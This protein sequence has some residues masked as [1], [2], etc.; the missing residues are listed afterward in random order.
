MSPGKTPSPVLLF[1]VVSEGLTYGTLVEESLNTTDDYVTILKAANVLWLEVEVFNRWLGIYLKSHAPEVNTA[2]LILQWFKYTAKNMV[3]EV[4]S[5][6]IGS[7]YDNSLI[8]ST[9]IVTKCHRSVI[10]KRESSVNAATQLLGETTQIINTLQDRE[11][12]DLDS[13]ELPFI[14]KW[15]DYFTYPSP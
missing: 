8:L 4:Q 3:T 12:P 1:L 13:A 5:T 14:D 9:V 6:D 11:L 15:H 2:G 10:E 7:T